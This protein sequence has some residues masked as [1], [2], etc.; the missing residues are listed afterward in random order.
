M[1]ELRQTLDFLYSTGELEIRVVRILPKIEF[2]NISYRIQ[3]EVTGVCQFVFEYDGANKLLLGADAFKIYS[4]CVLD[5][6]VTEIMSTFERD[7]GKCVD[8]LTLKDSSGEYI[9][10]QKGA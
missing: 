7:Y 1:E 8:T 5:Y 6:I 4:D 2:R 3:C 9:E 10:W